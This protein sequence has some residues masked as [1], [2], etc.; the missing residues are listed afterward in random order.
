MSE[1]RVASKTRNIPLYDVIP[2]EYVDIKRNYP[3][4]ELMQIQI[5]FRMGIIGASGSGK[6]VTTGNIVLGI[7]AFQRVI[8]CAKENNEP[9]Y[10]WLKEKYEEIGERVNSDIVTSIDDIGDLPEI[11]DFNFKLNNLVI[12]D[13]M[14]LEGKKLKKVEHF[15]T[16]GR[17]KNISCIFVSQSYFD[18]PKMIRKNMDYLLIRKVNS[19][20]DLSRILGEYQTGDDIV[21]VVQRYKSVMRDPDD[22]FTIDLLHKDVARYRYRRNLDP[23]LAETTIQHAPPEEKKKK[24]MKKVESYENDLQ[25]ALLMRS[26]ANAPVYSAIQRAPNYTAIQ[27]SPWRLRNNDPVIPLSALGIPSLLG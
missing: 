9:I 12:F 23:W 1:T 18:I 10:R 24:P 7:G 13:D 16:R 5:P 14:I 17:R 27:Q 3:T 11:E 6:T 8:I 25:P 22:Y 19:V 4:M 2:P 26:S 20:R 21:D 15:F